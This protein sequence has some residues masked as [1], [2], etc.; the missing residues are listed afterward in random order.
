MNNQLTI[1]EQYMIDHGM[2]QCGLCGCW[3]YVDSLHGDCKICSTA[4]YGAD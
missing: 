1:E 2:R 4:Q 3:D